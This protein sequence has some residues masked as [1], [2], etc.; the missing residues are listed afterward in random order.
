MPTVP[1]TPNP[2]TTEY[3]TAHWRA[4]HGA[5]VAHLLAARF[6]ECGCTIVAPVCAE[7]QALVQI[8]DD[9]AERLALAGDSTGTGHELRHWHADDVAC[10]GEFGAVMRCWTARCGFSAPCTQTP[11]TD[12]E[13]S[14]GR[15]LCPDCREEGGAP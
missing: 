5:A 7:G 9:A 4:A 11:I 8:A 1:Q 3:L 13:A 10:R 15:W 6:S 14:T 2:V 12:E